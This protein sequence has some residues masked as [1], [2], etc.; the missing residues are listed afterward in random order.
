MI[1]KICNSNSISSILA[2]N[3]KKVEGEVATPLSSNYMSLKA[4]FKQHLKYLNE[5]TSQDSRI[6]NVAKHIIIN[7]AENNLDDDTLNNIATDVMNQMG[8][9]NQPCLVV[10]HED[11]DKIHIHIVTT[12][13]DFNGNKIDTNYEK[14]R[15]F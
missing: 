8:W 4:S 13:I 10:K 7:P 2:Y 9:D 5:L 3:L 12:N 15:V 14:K 1:V 11:I 6:K